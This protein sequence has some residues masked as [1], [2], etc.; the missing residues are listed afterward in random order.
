MESLKA[1]PVPAT[2]TRAFRGFTNL[3][4][5][6]SRSH[7]IEDLLT[8]R[9]RNMKNMI[10]TVNW[11]ADFF[12]REGVDRGIPSQF[13]VVIPS[14]NSGP[15]WYHSYEVRLCCAH[16]NNDI[17]LRCSAYWVLL[18]SFASR[19]L[20]STILIQNF[21]ALTM[22]SGHVQPSLTWTLSDALK[23]L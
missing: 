3:S 16:E 13:G 15:S 23:H 14:L 22:L 4:S 12:K 7:R 21:R 11:F 18:W 5:V 6:Y 1:T 19:S 8:T 9:S 17:Q 20:L 2:V 10:F